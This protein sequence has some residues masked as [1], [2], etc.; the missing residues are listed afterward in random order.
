L[1][2]E[3]RAG[4]AI[5][6]IPTPS[7]EFVISNVFEQLLQRAAT[8]LHWV[9]KLAA[10]FGWSATDEDH[11][12]LRRRQTPL[13]ITGWHVIAG[14]VGGLM[15]GFAAHGGDAV[16]VFA[17]FYVLQVYVTIVALERSVACGMAILAAGRSENFVDFQKCFGRSS[18]IGLCI[19]GRGVHVRDSDYG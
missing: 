10:E 3:R 1:A 7:D 15:A 6:G 11:F 18:G 4:A 14:Q 19:S 12:V 5:A 2:A 17:A 16:T 9:L 13:G 8:S